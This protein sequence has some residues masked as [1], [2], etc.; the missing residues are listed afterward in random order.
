[1]DYYSFNIDKYRYNNILI[2]I[3]Y[4]SK[5]VITILYYKTITI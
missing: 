3:N 2:I 5:Q 4:L 1:M